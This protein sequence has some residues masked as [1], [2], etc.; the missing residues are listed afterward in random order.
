MLNCVLQTQNA[1]TNSPV[2]HLNECTK[3]EEIEMLVAV[4]TTFAASRKEP[5]VDVVERVHAAFLA[6]G[7]GEPNIHFM[8]SD[9]HVSGASLGIKRVSSVERVLKRFPQLERFVGVGHSPLQGESGPR[10]I[11]NLGKSGAVEPIEF[12]I[13]KEIARGVPKSFPCHGI[14]L[15]FSA[16]GF[17]EGPELPAYPD[18]Q[19]MRQLLQAGVDIASHSSCAGVT[20]KDSWWVN[21]RERS[22]TALRVIEADA[23]AKKLPAPPA[24]VASV[25]AGCG[26]VRKTIQL[27]LVIAPPKTPHD[28]VEPDGGSAP[29]ETNE[30]IRSVVRTYRAKLPE[31]LETLPH[32]LPQRIEAPVPAGGLGTPGPK[33]P[34][35]VRAFSPMGYD[36][37]GETGA[38]KL[39]RRTQGNLTVELDFD[40]GTWSNSLTAIMKVIGLVNGLGF[41]ATLMLPVSRSAARGVVHGVEMPGQFPI[42]G[43]ERWRQIV[44]NLAALVTE[45]DRTFVPAVEAISGPSPEWFRPEQT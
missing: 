43:P 39:K 18:A 28:V 14:R 15:H 42:G 32:D 3:I 24:N 37:R 29:A 25:F 40:V 27:P 6:A 21:G 4:F 34:D 12:A 5:L 44:D 41:K 13:L 2:C 9:P 1:V 11:S 16:P 35:L 22:L 19:T 36:C 23:M 20:V 10:V 30:A 8:L 7:F 31:L 45:L 38:F 17:S 26:K 33:K